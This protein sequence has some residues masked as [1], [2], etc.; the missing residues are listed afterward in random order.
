MYTICQ[1]IV[2]HTGWKNMLHINGA[3]TNYMTNKYKENSRQRIYFSI[4][5]VCFWCASCIDIE[6]MAANN[7]KCLYCY[8]T[9]LKLTPIILSSDHKNMKHKNYLC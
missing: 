4:C 5:N 7:S 9:V 6:K 8:N 3:S 2:I 1:A